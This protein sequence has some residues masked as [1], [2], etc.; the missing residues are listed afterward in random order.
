MGRYNQTCYVNETIA[1]ATLTVLYTT[2]LVGGTI[3]IIIM[4]FLLHRTNTRSMTT[5]VVINLLVVHGI[6]LLTIP[7]RIIYYVERKW[8]F[9]F[10]FC[11]MI[12]AM[13]HIHMYL[14]FIFYVAMLIIRYISYFKQ[15]DKIEFY[16]KLHSVV[17][18][19]AVWIIILLVLFPLFYLQY[20]NEDAN[21]SNGTAQ[22]F[23]FHKAI[24]NFSV[25]IL[26]YVVVVI[27]VTII[28]LLL[29]VQ[30]FIIVKVVSKLKKSSLEHQ[31][32]W[33]QLKSLF[34]ILVMITCFFPFHM[35]RIYYI[36]HTNECYFYNEI[37]LSITALSCL[38]LLSFAIQ[39]YFQKVL[40]HM[41]F[42]LRCFG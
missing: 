23:M 34:F 36:T 33:A 14:S 24:D 17:A 37:F 32:F 2:V 39:T 5:T 19:A 28:C 1:Y 26:N 27:V 41:T 38:D 42:K 15:K 25:K 35:F 16:R 40:K 9:G 8:R 3:G 18:S 29:A 31:E 13:I 21:E 22:C 20:G 7:F 4:S 11:R 6:F 10:P 30:I 12:S